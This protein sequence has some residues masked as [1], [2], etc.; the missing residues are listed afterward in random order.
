ME[1]AGV[2]YPGMAGRM[3]KEGMAGNLE[4]SCPCRNLGSAGWA[5]LCLA[6]G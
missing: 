1:Q 2:P 6:L 3:E 4:L 5:L